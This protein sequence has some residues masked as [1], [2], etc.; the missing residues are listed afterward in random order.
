MAANLS[1]YG[2]DN[3]TLGQPQSVFVASLERHLLQYRLGHEDEDHLAALYF[4]AQ[5]LLSQDERFLR[6]TLDLS[7]DDVR[8]IAASRYVSQPEITCSP[9]LV[10]V[11]GGALGP[12]SPAARQAE[13]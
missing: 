4:N 10:R 2:L 1:K 7:L 6:G 12:N 5:G 3:W 9:T 8:K 11:E 13:P